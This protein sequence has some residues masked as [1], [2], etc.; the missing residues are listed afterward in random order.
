VAGPDSGLLSRGVLGL[1]LVRIRPEVELVGGV[2]VV[3]GAGVGVRGIV[4]DDL[5]AGPTRNESFCVSP[6]S[7][8]ET[9]WEVLGV[10]HQHTMAR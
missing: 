3:A 9:K 10:G 1:G 7:I 2:R 6:A 5:L 4:G 8:A